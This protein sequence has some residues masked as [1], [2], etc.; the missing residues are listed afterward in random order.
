MALNRSALH[1]P[2]A[3]VDPR[4]RSGATTVT[5][6]P[7]SS[8]AAPTITAQQ[9]TS[10]SVAVPS[11]PQKPLLSSVVPTAPQE[12]STLAATPSITPQ[13]PLLSEQL[14]ESSS[15]AKTSLYESVEPKNVDVNEMAEEIQEGIQDKD[16]G[17]DVVENITSDIYQQRCQEC[18]RRSLNLLKALLAYPAS[19]EGRT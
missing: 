7:S 15:A 3:F 16:V 14:N 4:Y 6:P 9:E 8:A 5:H 13:A 2:Q 11:I 1:R 12:P 18:E 19:L 17:F 10:T